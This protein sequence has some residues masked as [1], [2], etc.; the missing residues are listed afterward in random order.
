[1]TEFKKVSY[2]RR[3]ESLDYDFTI[4]LPV[5]LADWDVFDYWEYERVRSMHDN[6]NK[7]DILFDVGAE[8]GWM[9]VVFA[10][11]CDV[12]LIEPTKE[13]WPNIYETWKANTKKEPAGCYSGLMS[14]KTDDTLEDFSWPK[15]SEGE[16]IDVNKYEYINQNSGNIGQMKLDDLVERSGVIPTAITIDVEG[17]EL[18][19]LQGAK[20]TLA[21]NNLKVW[22]SIHPDL[23]EKSFNHTKN[24]IHNFMEKL[25]YSKEYLATDHEEHWLYTK[26]AK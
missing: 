24:D 4:M 21:E 9:S 15:E 26:G 8:H 19:V 1:M 14:H 22:V 17:A 3:G 6:L 20:R 23:M 13:F 10:K 11:F 2:L 16:L 18:L 25:G 5:P 7:D 12:F